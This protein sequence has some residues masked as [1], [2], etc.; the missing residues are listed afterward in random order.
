MR[1]AVG[2][3]HAG[4][5]LKKMIVP[6]LEA[7]GH[8]VI[9][10]G[11]DSADSVDYPVHAA[12]AARLVSA[13]DADRAVLACGTGAGVSIVANK[14]AGVR[15]INAS[16]AEDAEMA[17]RHND[18]NVLALA[19]RRLAEGQ[20][21]DIVGAFLATQF[22]GGRHQRRVEQIG[23]IEEGEAPAGHSQEISNQAR[24]PS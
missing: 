14:F 6:A 15:A 1:V 18:A 9:D 10:C 19:G 2:V 13:G 11:T 7:A 20:V 5:P 3:D 22:E 12:R 8:E 24:H 16:D 17:R 21:E 4:F 23:Q